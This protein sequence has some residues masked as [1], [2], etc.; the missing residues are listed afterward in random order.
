MYLDRVHR[1][2]GELAELGCVEIDD[3]VPCTEDDLVALERQLGGRLPGAIR[4][5]YLWGGRDLGSLF[6]GMD[7]VDCSMQ[8][9][10]DYRPGCRETLE[11]AGEDPAI[12]DAHTLVIQMDYDGQFSFVRNNEGDDPPVYT[13]NEQ[14][15]TFCSCHRLSDYLGLLVEQYAGVEEIEL[16]RSIEDLDDL[17]VP[18]QAGADREVRHL[19]FSGEVHFAAVPDRV[20]DFTEL[21]SLDLVG[22]GVTALSSRIGELQF[23]T[24]LNL[25]RNKLSSLPMALAELSDLTDL[26]LADNPLESVIDVLPKLSALHFCHLSGNPLSPEEIS[27]L[28]RE[29]PQVEIT[30]RPA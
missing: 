4:E 5:L 3:M 10:H 27:Q 21:R 7:V 30:F 29:L 19:L 9:K 18:G 24:R 12:L 22:K 8:I 15:P 16:V 14:E 23:L 25:A 6:N 26:D 28:Q 20:F 2:L 17:P 11:E 1:R 13:H